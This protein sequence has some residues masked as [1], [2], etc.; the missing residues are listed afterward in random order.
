MTFALIRPDGRF[1]L[2]GTH[3][4]WHIEEMGMISIQ[5]E[6]SGVWSGRFWL[7]S[8]KSDD[9]PFSAW[10]NSCDGRVSGSTLEPK[11]FVSD[12]M[13]ELDASVRGHQDGEELILLKTYHGLKQEP[14][15]CEGEI[16][17]E[18]VRIVGRWYFGWPNEVTGAFEM[19]RDI[20]AATASKTEAIQT[21]I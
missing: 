12:E 14:I 17:D 21:E 6:I 3:F 4:F 9:I 7:D 19:L 15:Y 11:S 8:E 1:Y 10:L 13:E 16:V 5:S 2:P 18:G 20:S